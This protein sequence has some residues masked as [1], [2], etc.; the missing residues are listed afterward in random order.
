VTQLVV[1][2]SVVLKWVF[3]EEHTARARALYRSAVQ[4]GDSLVAPT[5][6]R[7]EVTN[8]V[9]QRYRR[10]LVTQEQAAQALETLLAMSPAIVDPIGL[11]TGAFDL[12]LRMALPA[13]YDALH[14]IA[15]Q[16]TGAEFWT[17]DGRLHASVRDALPW[18]RWIGEYGT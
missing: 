9:Y 17:A 3:E 12:A 2:A 18:V 8:A 5:I 15:A 1:D 11:H 16:Q 14:L 13:T 10:G 4:G 6:L 7:A